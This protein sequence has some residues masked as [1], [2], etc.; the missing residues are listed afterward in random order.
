[1]PCVLN[2]DDKAI[3]RVAAGAS[4]AANHLN[5]LQI[6]EN[7]NVNVSIFRAPAQEPQTFSEILA[8]RGT[9]NDATVTVYYC[10]EILDT[11]PRE[12]WRSRSLRHSTE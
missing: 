1:M 4:E 7:Y 12:R 8:R 5:S 11:Y 10:S 6:P 2:P 9:M 3:C